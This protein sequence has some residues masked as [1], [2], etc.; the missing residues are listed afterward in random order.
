MYG[1][2]QIYK[3]ELR[4]REYDSYRSVYCGLCHVLKQKFGNLAR[5]TALSYDM[6]FLILLLDSLYEP[7][8][9]AF[10]AR[11]V[12]HPIRK[13]HF[14]HN[15]M[16]DYAADMSLL[17]TVRKL[18]DDWQD[19]R[20]H[21]RRLLAALLSHASEST[22]ERYQQKAAVLEQELAAL[23]RLEQE[24]CTQPE[25]PAACFGRILAEIFDYRQDAW[26]ETLRNM[27]FFL[28]KFIY[29]S[30]AYDDLVRDQKKHCYNP[31]Q[32]ADVKDPAFHD[33]CEQLLRLMIAPA[34]QAFEYLPI[35]KHSEILR[36]ILYAGVWI[37]FY[38][39]KHSLLPDAPMPDTNSKEDFV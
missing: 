36:N 35:V 39:R 27:G 26:S 8:S 18:H 17:L 13:Q 24:N 38:R 32:D 9:T 31:F 37:P 5:I 20:K 23:H 2:V 15:A 22:A 29:L 16:T 4:F 3:P 12:A 25:L 28:G 7:I 21:F 6:T 30:D 11:C 14:F 10:D 33:S 34:A 1:Y 19:E